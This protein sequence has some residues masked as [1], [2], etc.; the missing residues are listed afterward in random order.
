MQDIRWLKHMESVE[1]DDDETLDVV[2]YYF[3]A[4]F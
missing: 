4:D 2:F 1:V 3:V